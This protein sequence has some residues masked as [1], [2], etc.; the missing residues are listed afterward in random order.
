M[1]ASLSFWYLF[2][3]SS[4]SFLRIGTLPTWKIWRNSIKIISPDLLL[5]QGLTHYVNNA[6]RTSHTFIS[7]PGK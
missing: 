3:H 2:C 6:T 4:G 5:H 1:P 7:I